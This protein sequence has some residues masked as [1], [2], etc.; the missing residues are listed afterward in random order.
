MFANV[1][2]HVFLLNDIHLVEVFIAAVM[3]GVPNSR[4]LFLSYSIFFES[5]FFNVISLILIVNTRE[6]MVLCVCVCVMCGVCWLSCSGHT[7]AT[8]RQRI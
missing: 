3:C 5:F 4:F 1:N 6:T 2:I 7:L 8:G